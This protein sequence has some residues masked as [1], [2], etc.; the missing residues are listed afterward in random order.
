M[1]AGDLLFNRKTT[2]D[3][4]A[5]NVSDVF[6]NKKDSLTQRFTKCTVDLENL[7]KDDKTYFTLK[8]AELEK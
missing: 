4:F 5:L 2:Q 6:S 1:A 3:K 8:I 7:K